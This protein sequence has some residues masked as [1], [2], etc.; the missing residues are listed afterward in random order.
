DF[1]VRWQPAQVGRTLDHGFDLAA[2]RKLIDVPAKSGD[3]ADFIQQGGM[4]KVGNCS[5]LTPDLS[6]QFRDVT[7]QFGSLVVQPVGLLLQPTNVHTDR[8]Y[9]L[10][11]AVMQFASQP[12]PLF[13]P[14]LQQPGRQ[15]TQAL[16]GFTQVRSSLLYS[17]FEFL[18][19][20]AKRLLCAIT[21]RN[22]ERLST[23]Q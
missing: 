13:I 23:Q 1:H 11:Y 16:I 12:S 5:N 4:K 21:I 20:L 7:N 8:G 14:H 2:F 17:P 19:R 10:A 18:T 6:D 9:E 15:L 3:K 22:V